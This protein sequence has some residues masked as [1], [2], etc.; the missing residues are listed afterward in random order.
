MVSDGL[1]KYI[2]ENSIKP[3]HMSVMLLIVSVYLFLV[4]LMIDLFKLILM[5]FVR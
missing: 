2:Q 1:T 4:Y 5:C 3:M